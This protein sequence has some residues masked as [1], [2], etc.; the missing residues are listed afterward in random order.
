MFF[1]TGDVQEVGEGQPIKIGGRIEGR[2]VVHFD[3]TVAG[4]G[5]VYLRMICR[6]EIV[7]E[8]TYTS[9]GVDDM[10]HIHIT[11]IADGDVQVVN[12]CVPAMVYRCSIFANGLPLG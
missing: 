8:A 7:G 9:T 5:D 1:A 2:C 6:G 3:A 10:G 4:K 11:A 12:C